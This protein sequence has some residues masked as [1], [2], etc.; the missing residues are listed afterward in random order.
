MRNSKGLKT[1]SKE[2]QNIK[3]QSAVISEIMDFQ[4]IHH[5]T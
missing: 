3:Y 4:V 2:K 5:Y 1:L